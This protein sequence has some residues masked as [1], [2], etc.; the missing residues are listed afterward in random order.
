MY[1]SYKSISIYNFIT[2]TDI[3]AEN[4]TQ[5]VEYLPQNAQNPECDPQHHTDGG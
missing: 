1:L 5:F 4:V 2:N 3:G